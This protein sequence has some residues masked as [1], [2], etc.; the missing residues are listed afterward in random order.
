MECR[1]QEK[2]VKSQI[3]G[4]EA[5]YFNHPSISVSVLSTCDALE[6][7]QTNVQNTDIEKTALLI[8]GTTQSQKE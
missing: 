3:G 8:T 6:H 2:N 5:L 7:R 4:F 1:A